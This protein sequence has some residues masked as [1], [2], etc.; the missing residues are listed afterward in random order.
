MYGRERRG[1]K[2]LALGLQHIS[3]IAAYRT[4]H[5]DDHIPTTGN[6]RA[7]PFLAED[8]AVQCGRFGRKSCSDMVVVLVVLVVLVVVVVILMGVVPVIVVVVGGSGG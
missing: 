1:E 8:S 5:A 4:L 7:V 2:K 6:E 3:S